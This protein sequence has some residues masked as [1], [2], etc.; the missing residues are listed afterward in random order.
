MTDTSVQAYIWMAV[1]YSLS[2]ATGSLSSL[3]PIIT[4]KGVKIF[5][6]EPAYGKYG[7]TSHHSHS[8]RG[9]VQEPQEPLP[10]NHRIMKKTT[11]DVELTSSESTEHIITHSSTV[12]CGRGGKLQWE[13]LEITLF[14]LSGEPYGRQGAREDVI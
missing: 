12:T 8:N 11:I 9:F 5:N 3:R 1:E 13:L 2:L 10:P 4:W 6:S 14:H 7:A